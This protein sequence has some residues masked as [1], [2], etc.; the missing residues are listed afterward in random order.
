MSRRNVGRTAGM[1]LVELVIA[2]CIATVS[3]GAIYALVRQSAFVVADM[4]DDGEALNLAESRLERLRAMPWS[5]LVNCGPAF[6]LEPAEGG[7]ASRLRECRCVGS[8][9]AVTRCDA[10]GVVSEYDDVRGVTVEVSWTGR[11]QR[12]RQ[13]VL[14][15]IMAE[16]HEVAP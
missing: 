4:R 7:E 16:S 5:G 12:R 1:A 8:I 14:S 6:E 2:I 15:T 13:V 3:F 11:N 10:A 9:S